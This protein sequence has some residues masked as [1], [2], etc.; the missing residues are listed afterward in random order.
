MAEFIEEYI[1]GKL[2][3]FRHSPHAGI[4]HAAKEKARP[5]TIILG[6]LRGDDLVHDGLLLTD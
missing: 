5:K 2:S 1:D 4:E 6:V 3:G